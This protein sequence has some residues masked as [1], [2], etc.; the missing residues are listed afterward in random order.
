MLDVRGLEKS[1]GA[2]PVLRGV[3]LNVAQGETV[4]LL[5]PS[6]CGKTTL[7]RIVAGLEQPDAGEVCLATQPL[8]G[9]PPHQRH[10]GLMFQDFALF[11]H[12]NVAQNVAFGLKMHGQSGRAAQARVAEMLDLVGLSALARRSVT[13]LSGGEQQRVALARSLAPRPRLLMLDEPLGALDA[14]LRERLALELRE[15]LDVADITALYVT[16]DQ[17]EALAVGDRVAVMN[18]GQLEQI[19]APQALY[20]RPATVVAA[21]FL[22]LTNI[23]PATYPEGGTLA[24]TALGMFVLS[25]A[26]PH[27]LLHPG[28]AHLSRQ[29]GPGHIPVRLAG[30]VFRGALVHLTVCHASGTCLHLALPSRAANFAP[31]E[32][33][34]LH[35][36]PEGVL[37]LR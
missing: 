2:L 4:C 11:P 35:V 6:G 12:L 31:E 13:E 5:G 8:R 26:A 20:L 16:H 21:R 17:Q 36:E 34:Y 3:S 7:L 14:A 22:G 25:E 10:L 29:A 19:D 28:Y 18:A 37:P 9:L 27:L 30:Q 24:H 1:Y 33:L 23:L 15:I 32:A